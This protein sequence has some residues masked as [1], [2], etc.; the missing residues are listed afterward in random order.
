MKFP[1][2]FAF[3]GLLLLALLPL[4]SPRGVA[5]AAAQQD[6]SAGNARVDQLLSQS[7]YEIKR[8]TANVWLIPFKGDS[9]KEFTVIL[10]TST[11]GNLLVIFVVVAEK[12]NINASPEL[13]LRMLWFNDELDRVKVGI[14]GDSDAFVRIDLGT[15]TLDLEELKV[16]I[17]QVAAAADDVHAAMEPHLNAPGAPASTP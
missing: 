8:P 9:L 10:S 15:R 6:S 14:D 5:K 12:K 4:A 7:G 11:N 13:W 3:V 2:R 17:K 16:N 1:M